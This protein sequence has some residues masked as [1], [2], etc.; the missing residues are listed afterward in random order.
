MSKPNILRVDNPHAIEILTS[1]RT[2]LREQLVAEGLGGLIQEQRGWLRAFKREGRIQQSGVRAANPSA[3]NLEASLFVPGATFLT[4]TAN[5][6]TRTKLLDYRLI[7]QHNQTTNG[8][9]ERDDTDFHCELS[10]ILEGEDRGGISATTRQKD[11]DGSTRYDAYRHVATETTRGES[12]LITNSEVL[13]AILANALAGI[14]LQQYG[15]E[16]QQA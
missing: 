15:L 3:Y 2:A 10:A 16:I 8:I 4:T 11:A 5:Q 13:D 14:S 1:H 12:R 9:E 6:G 7:T